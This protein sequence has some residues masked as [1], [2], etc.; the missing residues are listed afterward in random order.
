MLFQDA[1]IAI[2]SLVPLK[3]VWLNSRD[4]LKAIGLRVKASAVALEGF[5][6]RTD[7]GNQVLT[8]CQ[9]KAVPLAPKEISTAESRGREQRSPASRVESLPGEIQPARWLLWAK[10]VLNLELG[11]RRARAQKGA[12]TNAQLTLLRDTL[13]KAKGAAQT[14]PVC[15]HSGSKLAV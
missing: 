6:R 12:I 9:K 14:F 1:F 8:E 4:N 15:S 5:L 10:A 13:C 3:H 2:F 7:K 11:A